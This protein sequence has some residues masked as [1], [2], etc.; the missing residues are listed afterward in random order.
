MRIALVSLL[1][2]PLY[3]SWPQVQTQN[4]TCSAFLEL[5]WCGYT[6]RVMSNGLLNHVRL[7]LE[8]VTFFYHKNS[9][10]WVSAMNSLVFSHPSLLSIF[11]FTFPSPSTK[12]ASLSCSN[13]F[14]WNNI[15]NKLL[16]P[17]DRETYIS[18][19]VK[20]SLVFFVVVCRLELCIVDC[21]WQVLT[22]MQSLTQAWSL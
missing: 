8:M 3:S 15:Q 10:E 6:Q 16:L 14:A 13:I 1:S 4:M 12:H 9:L 22:K 2:L 5:I 17:M 7:V 11:I 18:S 19:S 20:Y 21:C